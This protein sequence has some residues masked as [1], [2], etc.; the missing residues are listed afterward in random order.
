MK[1]FVCMKSVPSTNEVRLDPETH[2]ILRSGRDSVINP[3]DL[4]ALE[5]AVQLKQQCGGAVT[6]LS[7]G[8]PDTAELLKDAVARGADRGV[9]LTDRAF[10]GSDTLATSSVLAAAVRYLG[11]ADLILCGRMAVDG[12]TA[13][14]GPELAEHLGLPH[15]TEVCAIDRISDGEIVVRHRTARALQILTVK[16][17]AVLTVVRELNTPSLPSLAGIRRGEAA[18]ILTLGAR[19]LGT[20]DSRTGLHGSPTQV[21]RTF[22]PKRDRETEYFPAPVSKQ[23]EQLLALRKEVR[24]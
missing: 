15:I 16:L 11:G 21:L 1:I 13:Q 5:A 4:H 20:D 14:I 2:T 19:E 7:M 9:L 3:F 17:P 12:D 24:R 23:A 10:A 22:V 18:E 6:A 8:I